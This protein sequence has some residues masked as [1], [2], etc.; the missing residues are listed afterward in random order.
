MAAHAARLAHAE[1]VRRF[2]LEHGLAE[3]GIAGEQQVPLGLDQRPL[4][5][6]LL[7]Q[8]SAPHHSPGR[9]CSSLT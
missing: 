8:L 3:P 4:A 9:R 1:L 2:L 5:V 6:G 7:V